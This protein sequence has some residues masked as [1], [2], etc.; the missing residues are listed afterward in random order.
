MLKVILDP[1]WQCHSDPDQ[2]DMEELVKVKPRQ[3][4]AFMAKTFPFTC[5][6]LLLFVVSCPFC[7]LYDGWM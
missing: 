2:C 5:L 1:E 6:L 3:A 4:L 7:Q